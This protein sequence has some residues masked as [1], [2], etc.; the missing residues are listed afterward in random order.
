MNS[1]CICK[2]LTHIFTRYGK[3]R[4]TFIILIEKDNLTEQNNNTFLE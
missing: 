1:S 2:R 3:M 4:S